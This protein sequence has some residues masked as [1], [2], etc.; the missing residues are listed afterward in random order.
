ETYDVVVTIPADNTAYEFN[1]TTEDRTRAASL[2]IGNGVKQLISPMPRLKYFEGMKMM[3]GMMK[4]NGDLDDMGMGMS[5]NK[6]DM[7]VVMYPEITGG[8]T[9]MN[10]SGSHPAN[11]DNKN[12]Y[13]ANALG[14]IITMNYAMMKSPGT[15]T[16]PKDAPVKEL[17]FT[18]TGNMNRYVWSIDNRVISESDKILVKKG[19]NLR[20]V[21]YNNSM[22]RHP[23]H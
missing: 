10:M 22:M 9:P 13:N 21:I 5:L 14:K 7:N 8:K 16:L 15:T 1:A 20:L 6:M 23:M 19:E 4:M 3:N 2:Y 12:R 17:H 11:H 18:L